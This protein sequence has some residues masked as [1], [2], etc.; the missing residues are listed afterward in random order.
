MLFR[1][2]RE[3][4]ERFGLFD[5]FA[6]IEKDPALYVKNFG[7]YEKFFEL[8]FPEDKN[9]IIKNWEHRTKFD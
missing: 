7:G 8:A 4:K 1:S 6:D 3:F 2:K 9:F 5:L